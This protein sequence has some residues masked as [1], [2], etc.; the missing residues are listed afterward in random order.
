ME[1]SN[2]EEALTPGSELILATIRNH[3]DR[4]DVKETSRKHYI[5]S[6]W[7]FESLIDADLNIHS[8]EGYEAEKVISVRAP[9]IKLRYSGENFIKS[10][11]KA[12]RDFTER[13]IISRKIG[14]ASCRERVS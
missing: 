10:Y 3:S 13:K 5:K 8:L 12:G 6:T 11:P 1:I 9:Y 2:I 14:R 7:S 4:E